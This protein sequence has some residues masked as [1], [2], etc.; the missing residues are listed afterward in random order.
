MKFERFTNHM[1]PQESGYI[2]F[3][4]FIIFLLVTSN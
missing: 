4:P 3:K 1:I 2:Y